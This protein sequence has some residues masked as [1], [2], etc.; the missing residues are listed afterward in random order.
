VLK[1]VLYE[2]VMGTFYERLE[3]GR[4]QTGKP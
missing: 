1:D 2:A 4:R 3:R